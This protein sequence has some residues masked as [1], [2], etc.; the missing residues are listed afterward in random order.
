M[1][2]MIQTLVIALI[3]LA[4]AAYAGRKVWNTLRPKK[5]AG[6]ATDCGCSTDAADGNDWAKT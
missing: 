1:S 3:V 2:P 4:A 6:C 5:S